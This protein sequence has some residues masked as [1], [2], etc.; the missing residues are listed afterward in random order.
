MQN[1]MSV[2]YKLLKGV[3]E[4]FILRLI[5]Q[6]GP[7]SRADIVKYTNLTAPTVT[8]ITNRL[9]ESRMIIEYMVGESSGGRPP[10]LLKMNPESLNI[11]VIHLSSNKLTGYITDGDINVINRAEH[12]IKDLKKDEILDLMISVIDRLKDGAAVELP[13]MGI[14]VHGPVKA[15]EGISVFAPNIGWKNVPIKHMVEDRFHIP[16]YVE[17]D[18][19]AMALGEYYYGTARDVSN[20]VFVK[21]GYGVGS[22]LILDGKL[23]RGLSDSAGEIGHNTIDVSGPQCSCGNYGCLEAMASENAL[24]KTMVKSLKEGRDSSVVSMAAGSLE[25]IT[26]EIIYAA[27][28]EGDVLAGR[29]LRQAA[30]YL[31]IGI[32]NVVN[33]FNPEMV[34]IGGGIVRAESL[35]KDIVLETVKSRAL[36]SCYVVS[37]IRFSDMGDEATLKGAADMVLGEVL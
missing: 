18:V 17:N 25:D 15:K 34:V 7:I 5:R 12:G 33:T 24:V 14:V 37:D 32:A 1:L 6:K 28:H 9:I 29:M 16:V 19:R 21:V 36:E 22:G 20:M 11:I 23:Y 13:G 30:R 3:N 27:A 26:P 31:G 8:N 35:I 2:S 10:V 4:S